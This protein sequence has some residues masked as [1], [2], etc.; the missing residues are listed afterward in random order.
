ME[1]SH[2]RQRL[3]CGDL[4]ENLWRIFLV[5]QVAILVAL[6]AV[7]FACRPK[8]PFANVTSNEPADGVHLT[9]LGLNDLHGAVEPSENIVQGKKVKV[10]GFDALDAYLTAA[11]VS[12]PN[13]LLFV[14]GD[15]FQGTPISNMFKGASIVPLYNKLGVTA[16][17][18]GNHDL[19]YGQPAF[20]AN[21]SNSSYPFVVGNVHKKGEPNTLPFGE[22][23]KFLR[24]KMVEVGG[25]RLG[26][27]GLSTLSTAIDTGPVNSAGLEFSDF[28]S[29]V[30]RDTA[31]LR[32]D[33]A[34]AIV[35]LAHDGGLCDI[36][37][38]A[39]QADACINTDPVSKLLS[40][41]PKGTINAVIAGHTHS[42]QAH[43]SNGVPVV[44][45]R[46]TVRSMS[47]IDLWVKPGRGVNS[48][49]LAKPRKPVYLCHQMFQ[50]FDS[51]DAS[52]L[53]SQA[54]I[55]SFVPAKYEGQD[56]VIGNAM[57]N[58]LKPYFDKIRPILDRVAATLPNV[59][60]NERTKESYASN[61]V[62]DIVGATY[63]R[64]TGKRV[65][66]AFTN[67]GQVRANFPQG[68]LT[69]EDIYVV[70]PFEFKIY[71]AQ[72]TG[73]EFNRIG[74]IFNVKPKD[75]SV[76]S[77]GWKILLKSDFPRHVGFIKPDG[78]RVRDDELVSVAL[79]GDYPETYPEI[80]AQAKAEGRLTGGS[81]LVRETLFEGFSLARA[82]LPASCRVAEPLSRNI[83]Q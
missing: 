1:P 80:F 28:K 68:T 33:G 76:V 11:R 67:S 58:M 82:N 27:I 56:I 72:L 51:C 2:S 54:D 9:L 26:I 14:A 37:K 60:V 53:T 71:Y 57:S 74:A 24:T 70:F 69:Y 63:A 20:I 45:N 22:T 61:C 55:G 8:Q 42:A 73:K 4:I 48:V 15:L 75:I 47:R 23:K 81:D 32:N 35:L 25:V 38:P 10:G 52:L 46:D 30:L 65:D 12:N 43:F 21:L 17:T 66:V 49:V 16:A 6:S 19:D 78:S 3:L 7:S 77:Q 83:I 62:T 39:E 36:T 41:L 50:N 40:E 59:V 31:E 13:T 79:L 44:Q 5:R 18:L 34:D 29:S 64:K